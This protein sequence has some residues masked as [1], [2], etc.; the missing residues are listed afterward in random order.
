MGCFYFGFL[1]GACFFRFWPSLDFCFLVVLGVILG[2]FCKEDE[3]GEED[4]KKERL[5]FL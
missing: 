4:H 2:L 3:D 1:V 5:V